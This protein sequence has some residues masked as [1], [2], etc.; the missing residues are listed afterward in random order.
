MEIV[1]LTLMRQSVLLITLVLG[2]KQ[3]LWIVYVNFNLKS[4][5][6]LLPSMIVVHS[7]P[8]I[9][10]SKKQHKYISFQRKR[11]ENKLNR[12]TLD[13]MGSIM[14]VNMSMLTMRLKILSWMCQ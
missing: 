10:L 6:Y 1:L 9:Q 11:K 7:Q 14:P 13:L 8:K 5:A 12:N 2:V 4:R 3:L